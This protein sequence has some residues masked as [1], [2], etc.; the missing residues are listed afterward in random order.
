MIG[1]VDKAAP[2]PAG[3]L[4]VRDTQRSL[5]GAQGEAD[6]TVEANLEKQVGRSK[7]EAEE[8]VGCGQEAS[9]A[10]HNDGPALRQ[11]STGPGAGTRS[12]DAGVTLASRTLR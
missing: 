6:P 10:R 12:L 9:F 7:A 3:Q 1:G 11:R 4:C 5:A 2:G 8:S